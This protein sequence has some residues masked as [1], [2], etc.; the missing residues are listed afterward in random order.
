MKIFKIIT[1]LLLTILFVNCS[2]DNDNSPT[3]SHD[4]YVVGNE[5]NGSTDIA[6]LWKNG[7]V[8]NISDG[9]KSA[10][11]SSVFSSGSDVYVSGGESNGSNY[12]AKIWKNGVAQC[13]ICI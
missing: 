2:K 4:I 6:K 1:L 7:I 13:E 3:T 9:T 12:V 5:N 10:Y 11:V 8:Q